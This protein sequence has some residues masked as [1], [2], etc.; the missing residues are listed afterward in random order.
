MDNERVILAIGR[1]ERALSRI[2][3]AKNRPEAN[4]DPALEARHEA[5]KAEMKQAIRT[6]DG[7]IERQEH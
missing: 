4:I 6:I 2:E 3:S 1:I 5:L 7:L